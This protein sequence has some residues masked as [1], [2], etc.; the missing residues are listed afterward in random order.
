MA[1]DELSDPHRDYHNQTEKLCV[2]RLQT[3]GS[4]S[5]PPFS[6]DVSGVPPESE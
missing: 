6:N 1:A 4:L 2:H 3:E 5:Q